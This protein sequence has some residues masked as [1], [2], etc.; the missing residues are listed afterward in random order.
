MDIPAASDLTLTLLHSTLQLSS[1]PRGAVLSCGCAGAVHD[2]GSN[3]C[4][5]LRDERRILSHDGIATPIRRGERCRAAAGAG[6]RQSSNPPCIPST[7]RVHESCAQWHTQPRCTAA[8][9]AEQQQ[10]ASMLCRYER[11]GRIHAGA[12]LRWKIISTST[13]AQPHP[14]APARA[15]CSA[16]WLH[17]PCQHA[18]AQ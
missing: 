14:W 2:E 17:S 9:F 3:F 7:H 15:V 16:R 18:A 13:V 5:E 4:N 6:A 11:T 1:F 10:F 8:D 12:Q